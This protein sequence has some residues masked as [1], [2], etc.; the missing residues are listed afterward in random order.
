MVQRST[1]RG[2]P[3]VLLF[4]L[5][6]AALWAIGLAG[7]AFVW[8]VFVEPYRIVVEHV[9]VEKKIAAGGGEGSLRVAFFSDPDMKGSLGRRER[10]VLKII[11]RL[12][13][14]VVAVGGDLFGGPPKDPG[15]EILQELGEWLGEIA[16]HT[17]HGVFLVWGEQEEAYSERIEEFLPPNVRSLEEGQIVL[18]AGDAHVRLCGPEG[19]LAPMTVDDG[20]LRS[21]GSASFTVSSYVRGESAEWGMIE[22]TGRFRYERHGNAPGVA[23]LVRDDN[24]GIGFRISPE[25]AEWQW[26]PNGSTWHGRKGGKISL[27]SDRW[28]RVRVRVEVDESVTR[29]LSK[30]WLES[31][32]EPRSWGADMVRRDAQRPRA[33]SV[34]ILAGG[35][36]TQ[37]GRHAWDDLEVRSIDGELLL[38]ES[39]EDPATFAVDWRN[40]GGTR[41]DY[42]ATVMIVHS[43]TQQ[44]GLARHRNLDGIIAGHTH[45]GQVRLP[46]FSPVAM[47]PSIPAGW[48][49]GMTRLYD[50]KRWLYVSRGIGTTGAPI[51]L[52][53]PPEVTELTVHVSPRPSR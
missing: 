9:D 1:R 4:S 15:D 33:G 16:A 23:V 14:D 17:R 39:F 52:F 28:I 48:I 53:C 30:A 35:P 29:I 31:E 46:P 37:T 26:L 41:D 36:H 21:P 34:G 7:C 2:F 42:D 50:K 18:P 51:R 49:A 3:R 22:L 13:P 5:I 24:P 10:K 19:H 40:P 6:S 8:A 45:G 38:S 25:T 12:S 44:M 20:V 27:P 43:P 47:D 32:S 11:E